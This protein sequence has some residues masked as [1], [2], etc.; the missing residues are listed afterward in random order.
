MNLNRATEP[1]LDTVPAGWRSSRIKNVAQLSPSY[2]DGPPAPNEL[3]TVVPMEFLSEFGS[4]DV[5]SAQPFEVVR[6]V[7]VPFRQAD[8][9]DAEDAAGTFPL[10]H[11]QRR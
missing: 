9:A 6:L 8:E 1:W 10:R 4:I 3:C 7:R 11:H 2:S 5:T